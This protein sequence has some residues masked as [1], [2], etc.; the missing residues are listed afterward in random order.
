MWTREKD[1]EDP[2]LFQYS[3]YDVDNNLHDRVGGFVDAQAADQAAEIAHRQFLMDQ[4]IF[5]GQLDGDD[6]MS[7]EELMELSDDDLL[8]LVME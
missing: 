7:D 4:G 8:D 5:G 1:K 3:I 2:N 6:L